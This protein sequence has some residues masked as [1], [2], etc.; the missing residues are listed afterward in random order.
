MEGGKSWGDMRSQQKY[1][2]LS[3]ITALVITIK[4]LF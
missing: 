2:K 1:E 3:L 4:E